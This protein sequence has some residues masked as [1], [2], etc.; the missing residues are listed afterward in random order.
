MQEPPAHTE[1]RPVLVPRVR[2]G[3]PAVKGALDPTVVHRIVRAN[4]GEVRHCYHRGLAR[5]PTLEG[6]VVIQLVV[7]PDG[8]VP[9]AVVAKSTLRDSR[10]ASCIARAVERWRFPKPPGCGTVMVDQSFVLEPGTP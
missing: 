3:K 7:R 1:R 5:N 9:V 2:Q 4:L 6:R 8:S 10:V